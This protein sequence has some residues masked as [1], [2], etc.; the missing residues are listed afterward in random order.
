MCGKARA[1]A[2]PALLEDMLIWIHIFW[3]FF[4]K[5]RLD[6]VLTYIFRYVSWIHQNHIRTFTVAYKEKK[7]HTSW[8][9]GIT[10]GEN[11]WEKGGWKRKFLVFYYMVWLKSN[12]NKCNSKFFDMSNLKNEKLSKLHLNN[13]GWV[14]IYFFQ[15]SIISQ[16]RDE[17]LIMT[18]SIS[19][20]LSI[21]LVSFLISW[22]HLKDLR[23]QK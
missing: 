16:V 1:P 6:L 13:F 19:S 14:I 23:T 20:K 21:C 22:K 10:V 2:V 7:K 3:R 5:Y 9:N 15:P 18:S 4:K 11:I 17:V 12:F 8:R